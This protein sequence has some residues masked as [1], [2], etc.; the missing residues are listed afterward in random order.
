MLSAS[1]GLSRAQSDIN[2]AGYTLTFDDE[3]TNTLSVTTSFTEGRSYLVIFGL[4][5]APRV[6]IPSPRGTSPSFSVNSGIFERT[7]PSSTPATTGIRATLSSM[8]TTAAGFSQQYGYFEIRCQMPSSGTGSTTA[9]LAD[10][11]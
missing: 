6:L 4:P 8:D 11:Q 3:F 9:F 5:M 2:L 7:R 1:V 10:G